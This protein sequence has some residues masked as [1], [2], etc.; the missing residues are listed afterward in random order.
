MCGGWRKEEESVLVVGVVVCG[1]GE[2][3]VRLV[4]KKTSRKGTAAVRAAK[5]KWRGK[6]GTVG[7]TVD[8]T[9]TTSSPQNSKVNNF[10]HFDAT[11][12]LAELTLQPFSS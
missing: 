4:E 11:S 9:V 1:G 2:E 3:H 10:F 8:S 7:A 5:Q 12:V 6:E